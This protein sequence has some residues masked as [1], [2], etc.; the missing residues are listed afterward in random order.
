[1]V[2]YVLNAIVVVALFRFGFFYERGTPLT[3]EIRGEI[4][5]GS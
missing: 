1:M 4:Y 2:F 5:E 3:V